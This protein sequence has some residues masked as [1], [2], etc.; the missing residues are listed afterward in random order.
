MHIFSY[1]KAMCLAAK[2]KNLYKRINQ[3]ASIMDVENK[4]KKIEII[5][6]KEYIKW[7]K[8]KIKVYEEII[9]EAEKHVG[10]KCVCE[11]GCSACCMQAIYINPA[12][13]SIIE[14]YVEQ[15]GYTE[16]ENLKKKVQEALEKIKKLDI[17]MKVVDG[18]QEEQDR[19]NQLFYNCKIRC[20]FLNQN[21]LCSIYEIRPCVCWT[22]RNYKNKEECQKCFNPE[23]SCAFV[24]LDI[25]MTK[26][27]YNH[28]AKFIKHKEYYLLIYAIAKILFVY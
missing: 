13:Y 12:E 22:Y 1:L 26:D 24:S 3:K 11:K 10:L 16:K 5:S 19:I 21:N 23:H 17:P 4:E 9:D 2:V 15:L 7:C 28:G 20:P 27:M 14:K 25:V 6:I 18:S 8:S